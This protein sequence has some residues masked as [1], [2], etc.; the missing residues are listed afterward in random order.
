MF[1]PFPTVFG[2]HVNANKTEYMWFKRKGTI[3]TLSGVPL[4]IGD[5]ITY[6]SSSVSSIKSDV[7][8]VLAKAETTIDR[9]SIM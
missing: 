3:L 1:L 2:L 6:L 7:Y 5:K 8:I 4:K 9:L